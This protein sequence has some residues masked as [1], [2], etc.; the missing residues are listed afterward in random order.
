MKQA[1]PTLTPT[2]LY[3]NRLYLKLIGHV[4]GKFLDI[5]TGHGFLLRPLAQRGFKGDAIDNSDQALTIARR[6]TKGSDITVTK[7]DFYNWPL[8]KKYDLI[9]CLE[10]LEY[11]KDPQRFINK[12]ARHLRKDGRL[13]LSLPAHQKYWNQL[14]IKRGHLQRFEKNDLLKL[15]RQS[16]LRVTKF[17]SYGYPFLTI[18]R[19]LNHSAKLVKLP[20][21]KNSNLSQ[22]SSLIQEYN[23]RFKFLFQ[24]WLMEPFFLIM[25]KFLTSDKGVGFLVEAKLSNN[26]H[27]T[28]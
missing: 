16:G 1:Q 14:D 17:Y 24:P 23:P 10:V 8:S 26:A 27:G 9:L 21:G 20:H 13:I 19:G 2:F 25:D 4:K 22:D 6:F 7:A 5:G 12:M 15:F 18:L 28:R 11:I 3:R